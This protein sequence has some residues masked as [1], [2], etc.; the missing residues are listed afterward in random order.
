MRAGVPDCK[1]ENDT[2]CRPEV[3]ANVP[4]S[5]MSCILLQTGTAEVGDA[6]GNSLVLSRILFDSGSQKSYI[7]EEL[8]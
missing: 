1:K 7:A 5:H 4:S 3:N 6:D 8:A 2:G